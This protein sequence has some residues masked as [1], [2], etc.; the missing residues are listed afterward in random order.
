MIV[1]LYVFGL[2]LIV[3]IA[4]RSPCGIVNEDHSVDTS[5]SRQ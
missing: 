5:G 2:L 4:S 1:H 3:P